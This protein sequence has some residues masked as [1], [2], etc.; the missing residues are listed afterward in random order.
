[1]TQP[2]EPRTA[3]GR[4]W[5]EQ[6]HTGRLVDYRD[7]DASRPTRRPV[8]PLGLN[9]PVGSPE[10]IHGSISPPADGQ[11]MRLPVKTKPGPVE[12]RPP[13]SG[14]SGRSAIVE[15]VRDDFSVG[16]LTIPRRSSKRPGG[17]GR[18][19]TTI[20]GTE[21]SGSGSA[22]KA[23]RKFL[24]LATKHKT[25]KSTSSPN[26][27]STEGQ[28][29]GAG[30]SYPS[31]P[32]TEFPPTDTK[33]RETPPPNW[34][35]Q[36]LASHPPDRLPSSINAIKRKPPPPSAQVSQASAYLTPNAK[37]SDDTGNLAAPVS[38][39][40]ART[41]D[42][43]VQPPSRFSITTYATSNPGTPRQSAEENIPPLPN[44]PPVASVMDRGRPLDSSR[45]GPSSSEEPIPITMSSPYTAVEPPQGQHQR[46]VSDMKSADRRASTLSISKPLPPAPP[47]LSTP[48]D[49]VSHLRAQINAL[50][51]RRI[52]IEKSIKQMT[53]LMPEDNWTASQDVLRKREEEKQKV[54]GL[55]TELAEVMGKEHD[56]GLKL[57]RAYKRQD[58]DAT[59]EP[60]EFWVRRV[61]G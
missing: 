16:P 10:D 32:S 44:M 61:A 13:W 58:M 2:P 21:T 41:D 39:S 60:A 42:A 55:K 7:G 4:A 24:P 57:Y 20:S 26:Q 14:A 56:L 18:L 11:R 40:P 23:M 8:P 30:E 9:T 15:P 37:S 27:L 25:R 28:F 49:R 52:N 51:H 1:M 3:S 5:N 43:W 22:G 34:H 29:R 54:A 45:T 6:V 19:S 12:S 53:L 31:P 48:N 35:N 46:A 17:K 38:P 47:E 59:Y 33:S 36:A 50:T